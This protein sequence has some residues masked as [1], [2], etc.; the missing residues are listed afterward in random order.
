MAGDDIPDFSDKDEAELR[1][2]TKQG[3]MRER[4][5]AEGELE[6][7]QLLRESEYQAD[8]DAQ[9][10]KFQQQLLERQ[11][12]AADRVAERQ[13]ELAAVSAKAARRSMRAAGLAAA[14][15]AIIAA[16]TGV[17]VWLAVSQRGQ[18]VQ[19]IVSEP[20]KI[21]APAAGEQPPQ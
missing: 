5:A 18:P 19:V 13:I 16:L 15:T 7:R 3:S 21:E 10:Q 17:Q 20:V 6:R 11:L 9:A 8:R 12:A 1:Q 14:A 4:T 2:L